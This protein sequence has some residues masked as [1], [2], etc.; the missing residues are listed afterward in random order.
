MIIKPGLAT[1][2]AKKKKPSQ[3]F[4]SFH[5]KGIVNN[6]FT[7]YYTQ[8]DIYIPIGEVFDL[9]KINNKIDKKNNTISGF[10]INSKTKYKIDFSNL[11]A[12]V[13]KK[14]YKITQNDFIAS[15]L[16]Y[17]VKLSVFKKLFGLNFT[18]NMRDLSL[19]LTSNETLPI[20][21]NLQRQQKNR[22]ISNVYQGKT[23][24]PLIFNRKRYLI[25]TGM[26]DYNISTNYN[27]S[28]FGNAVNLTGGLKFL[29]GN[30]IGDVS[31]NY[32]SHILTGGLSSLQWQ[33][34]AHD[35]DPV[36][37]VYLGD[38]YSNGLNSQGFEGIRITN[39]PIHERIRF[40]KYVVDGYTKPDY[41]VEL[42]L[43]GRLVA[44][45]KTGNDGHYHLIIPLDYG[46]SSLEIKFYGPEGEFREERRRIQIPY[47]FLPKGEFSYSLNLGGLTPNRQTFYENP[48]SRFVAPNIAMGLTKWFTDKMGVDYGLK[49]VFYNTSSFRISTPYLAALTV[50]PRNLYQFSLSGLYPSQT[51]FQIQA[52]HYGKDYYY[53]SYKFSYDQGK[54]SLYLPFHVFKHPF[55]LRLRGNIQHML[56]Q[57]NYGYGVGVNANWNRLTLS[58]SFNMNSNGGNTQI[59]NAYLSLVNAKKLPFFLN[60]SLISG[61]LHY[62]G[63]LHRFTNFGLEYSRTV[64]KYARLQLSWFRDLT[65]H[66]SAFEFRLIFN[67]PS[68]ISTSS[69]Q[70]TSNRYVMS[71]DFRGGIGFDSHNRNFMFNNRRLTGSASA[72]VRM[73]VDYNGNGVQDK[74]EPNIKNGAIS[75]DQAVSQRKDKSGLIH[76]TNLQPYYRYNITVDASGVRNPLWVP[77]KTQFSFIANPNIVTPIEIPFYVSGVVNG[78][79]KQHGNGIPGMKVHFIQ[80]NGKYKKTITTFSDGTFYY[81]GLPPGKYETY[82]D[83]SQMRILKSVSLPADR[84]FTIKYSKKGVTI[85]HLN[86]KLLNKNSL[87]KVQKD[88]TKRAIQIGSFH[89]ID[90]AVQVLNHLKKEH[91]PL[92]YI[93]YFSPDSLFR[94]TTNCIS[95]KGQ[96][97]SLLKVVRKD[98]PGAIERKCSTLSPKMKYNVQIGAFRLKKRANRYKKFASTRITQPIHIKDD[99]TVHWFKLKLPTDSTWSS[100]MKRRNYARSKVFKQAFISLYPEKLW[101]NDDFYYK[102]QLGAYEVKSA[103]KYYQDKLKTELGFNTTVFLDKAAKVY[104]LLLKKNYHWQKALIVRHKVQQVKGINNIA[105]VMFKKKLTEK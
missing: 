57:F 6:V 50:S 66:Q 3:I 27:G 23:F 86:F 70:E 42:F 14:K 43:N 91:L 20:E 84:K 61:S 35:G 51:S 49:P 79:V 59:T 87:K 45:T 92:F 36:T 47:T 103:A 76:V 75:F 65:R 53:N 78:S 44:H 68:M 88:T 16:D 83:S 15:R 80:L 40:G 55:N 48:E 100:A 60:G 98:Y 104:R 56:S 30:L 21:A 7:V 99:S 2:Q 32:Q 82:P 28:T 8:K 105:I 10:Y 94:V 13:G 101:L 4:L 46:T 90:H 25:K 77:S 74:G 1:A 19:S 31:S 22:S 12:F 96:V 63:S 97:D 5:Y 72:A 67:L 26:L 54:G 93:R 38:L 89:N 18:P 33:Y 52:S 62:N 64:L 37:Q 85:S 24:Y 73:F 71:Q 58:S 69:Y 41:D 95:Q 29:E 81:I 34:V 39:E 102:I 17:Y 9:L 11:T